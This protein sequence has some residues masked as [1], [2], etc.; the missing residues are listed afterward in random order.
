MENEKKLNPIAGTKY[1]YSIPDGI[2][3]QD[4]FMQMVLMGKVSSNKFSIL[5][6][7]K[8]WEKI[9]KNNSESESNT[10]NAPMFSVT[11]NNHVDDNTIFLNKRL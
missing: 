8:T 2:T 10:A 1:G 7:S 6:N 11:I 3:S 9:S 5:M 4:I